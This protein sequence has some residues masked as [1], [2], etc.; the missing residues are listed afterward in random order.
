MTQFE[1]VYVN[2]DGSVRELSILEKLNLRTMYHGN[3]GGRP[4]IKDSYSS[5][6][7]R[8]DKSGYCERN[9]IPKSKVIQPYPKTIT[10]EQIKEFIEN[11]KDMGYSIDF[12][13]LKEECGDVF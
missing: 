12:T 3:D 8:G 9:S 4:Y 11:V 6:D 7:G 1:Y 13:G 2:T 5:K 10:T